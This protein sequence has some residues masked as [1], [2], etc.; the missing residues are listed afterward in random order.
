MRKILLAIL[1]AALASPQLSSIQASPILTGT[2]KDASGVVISGAGVSLERLPPYPKGGAWRATLYATSDQNGAFRV[3]NGI[4]PGSYRICAQAANATWLDPCRWGS[5][6][7]QVSF[8]SGNSSVS[9]AL[10]V[11][12]A[13]AVAIMVQDSGQLLAKNLGITAGADLLLGISDD[14][15]RF[16]SAQLLSQTPTVRNYQILVPYDRTVNLVAASTFFQLRNALGS[17]LPSAGSTVF[18]VHAV[19]G[20][21][22][23]TISLNV[24]GV[25][26]STGSAQ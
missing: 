24:T 25:T 11:A 26:K 9:F 8:P 2:I 14:A 12:K 20:Q 4:V 23:P 5:P 7:P 17:L 6:A 3:A 18:P 19:S 13:A 21:S 16:Q 22:P 1:V 10:V 15:F